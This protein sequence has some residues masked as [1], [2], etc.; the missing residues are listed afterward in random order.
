MIIKQTLDAYAA[1]LDK[2]W[3][4][5]RTSTV[6]ASEV[7]QCAR[8][9]FWLKNENDSARRVERDPEYQD[10]WGA[11]MRGT[12][13]EDAFWQPAMKARFGDRLIYS[14]KEQKTFVLNYLSATPDGMINDLTEEESKQIGV[15]ANCVMVECKTADPRTNLASAKQANVFQTQVQM[16]L[17]RELHDFSYR[18]THSVLS[19]IDA[20]FWSDVKEF[21]IAFDERIYETAKERAMQIM[22]ADSGADLKPEGWI[23]GAK[24]CNYCPFTKACGIERRNLPF[25]DIAPIDAQFAEEITQMARQLRTFEAGRDGLDAEYRG[26]Q[27]AIKARL[28]EKG[29]KKIPGVVN[30][31]QVKGR[32]SYDAKAIREA[33]AG[34]GVDIEQFATVGEPSDRLAILIGSSKDD[35]MPSPAIAGA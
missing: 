20:S 10:S 4:H 23:A 1:S 15:V 19:Y 29:V 33:A 13:I 27:E 16:G 9:V 22:T 26:L 35:P 34:A 6:G 17:V 21:V 12:V 31:S 8:K 5:D 14:G 7:G 28:R 18:P 25:Q 3:D 11:R 24:E 2:S 30:W 32:G